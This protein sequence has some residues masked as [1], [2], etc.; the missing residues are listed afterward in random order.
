LLNFSSFFRPHPNLSDEVNHNFVQSEIEG[1]VRLEDLRPGS[2]LEVT[3]HNTRYKL[4]V[5]N[6]NTA[7]IT[8]HPL[9]CP[10]PVLVR[11]NGSTWGGSMLKVRFIGR[12]M[13]M[14]FVHPQYQTAIITSPIREIRECLQPRQSKMAAMA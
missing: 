5:L 13:C 1:G 12:G 4:L 9:Y 3:T 14:E 8:G 6:G 7:L 2:R 10:S 11:I